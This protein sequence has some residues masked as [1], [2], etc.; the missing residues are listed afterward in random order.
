[1]PGGKASV[2]LSICEK[3]SSE[4]CVLRV[5]VLSAV[6]LCL[7]VHKWEWGTSEGYASMYV[8]AS[9]VLSH[10][11]KAADVDGMAEMGLGIVCRDG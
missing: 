6:L 1:M 3:S 4:V 2:L 11:R 5:P 9:S 8:L 10:L 7:L